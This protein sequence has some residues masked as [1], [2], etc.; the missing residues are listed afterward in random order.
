MNLRLLRLPE[1]LNKTGLKRTALYERMKEDKF[2][3]AVPIGDG[4]AVGWPEHEVDAYIAACIAARDAVQSPKPR[5][6]RG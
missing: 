5:T 1:V 4:Q 6:R 2:P 3:R